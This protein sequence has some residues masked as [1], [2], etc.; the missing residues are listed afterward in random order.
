VDDCC[1]RLQPHLGLDLRDVLYSDAE[2]ADDC[3][4]RL[5]QTSLTQPAL[6]VIEY[7]ASRLLRSWGIAPSAMIG[8]SIGEY[9]AAHLAGVFT[10]DDALA[11]VAERGR[12]MQSMPAG[13]MLAVQAS[14]A[15]VS[16]WLSAEI[17]LAAVNAPASC[18]LAGSSD[19][20]QRLQETLADR[21]LTCRRLQTSHAFHSSSMDPILDVFAE[22]VAQVRREK[23]AIPFVSNLTGT[24][25]TADEATRPE[26]WARHLRGTVR[27]SDGVRLLTAQ[28]GTVLVEVGPGNT[29]STFARQ[30]VDRST[31]CTVLGT[32]RHPKDDHDDR[33]VLLGAAGRLWLAGVHLDWARLHDG[34]VRRRIPLPTYSFDRER[35]WVEED[36][37]FTQAKAIARGG[38]R[39][40]R[41]LT[42]WFYQPSWHRFMPAELLADPVYPPRASWVVFLDRAGVG[43]RAAQALRDAD[44]TVLTVGYGESSGA[45][46]T[47][48]PGNPE[49]YHGL[50][51]TL[52]SRKAT[53]THVLHVWGVSAD[54]EREPTPERVD[55]SQELGFYS[56][57]FLAQALGRE[58]VKHPLTIVTVSNDMQEVIGGELARPDKATVMGPVR[59]LPY[60]FQ[61]ITCLCID[62]QLPAGD[63]ARETLARRLIAEA[64]REVDDRVIAY[65][66]RH[67]WV[68]TLESTPIA[69]ATD[70]PLKA[71][72]TYLITGGQ[73]GVG[74]ALAEYLASDFK[75]RLLLTARSPLPPE[76]DWEGWLT[77]HADGDPVSRRI[78]QIQRL[79][80][81]GADV[82]TVAADVTDLAAMQRAVA[83]AHERFGP[84]DGVIHAA[85]VA[86]GGIVQMKQREVAAKVL[87]PKVKGTYV[88]QEAL[89]N[90][91]LQFVVLCSSTAALIGG[92]GQVDY[93]GA[94]AF[95]DAFA[96]WSDDGSGPRVISINWDTWKDVGMA[97]NT[98]VTGAAMRII[99]EVSLKLGVSPAEGVE[100]FRRVLSRGLPQLAVVPLDLTPVLVRIQRPKKKDLE[101]EFQT[102]GD[103]AAATL[104]G[105]APA[106]VATDLERAIGD[107]WNEVLGRRPGA[108]DNFFELGGDSM[109]A[110]QVTA[111]MKARLGKEITLVKLYEMPTVSLLARSLEGEHRTEDAADALAG[112]DRRAETR[113]ESMQRRRRART[114][115][116]L[117]ESAS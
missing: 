16:P 112:V 39:Q 29:L 116:P 91:P 71:R 61:N 111:L 6:F 41:E 62:A 98:A 85:G 72:G 86:G 2:A 59:V 88:L 31:P 15:D 48:E 96:H 22:R 7:A 57:L 114:E 66:G 76:T 8:H 108:N 107:I 81:L 113:R 32:L 12:L 14:E 82:L 103:T 47:I 24:W 110:I 45:E 25:I 18:V 63:A 106:A 109:T 78:R 101:A 84:I 17:C 10:L 89:K 11:L 102:S 79:Q 3:A 20:I 104:E 95:L 58:D 55:L 1:T 97:V 92:F 28:T 100:A 38:S 90:E 56:L 53:P 67:R 43:A 87:E 42:R 30:H 115:Q 83:L 51:R 33:Q 70:L 26:Y 9:V 4:E 36:D 77:A 73:G 49:D 46:V 80:E 50:V 5:K 23:P 54:D 37:L 93:C 60:E 40:R 52:V 64:L 69:A 117:L 13:A 34:D 35:Y 44:Q 94:N 99:R 19:A 74:F 65:R 68:Q 75:A 27:F 21:G 105:A